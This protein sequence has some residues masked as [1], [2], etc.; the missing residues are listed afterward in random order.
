MGDDSGGPESVH[1]LMPPDYLKAL[2]G[3]GM[4]A[5]EYLSRFVRKT[6]GV[7]VTQHG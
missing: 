5:S 7:R 6:S 4:S 1:L 2:A 3:G